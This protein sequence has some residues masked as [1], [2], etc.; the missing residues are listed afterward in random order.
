LRE[1]VVGRA[2]LDVV[3]E[4]GG[5]QRTAMPANIRT[6]FWSSV[7]DSCQRQRCPGIGS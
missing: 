6:F 2:A 5:Q 7:V 3:G 4:V 1:R